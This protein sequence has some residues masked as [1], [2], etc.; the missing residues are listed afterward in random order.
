MT[1][2][3]KITAI[4]AMVLVI[5]ATSITA[6]AASRYSSPAEAVA[7]LTGKTV[8]SVIQERQDT[9]KSYGAIAED[10]GKLEEFKQEK[11]QILKDNL[12]KR[13]AD[14]TITQER[15]DEIVKAVEERQAVCDGTGTGGAGCGM[16]AGLGRGNG[17]GCGMGGCNQ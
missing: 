17:R 11:L 12:A 1:K 13:V 14:G 3:K 4:G 2:I 5:G 7:G 16:G 15:A 10:A 9:G 6:F 8:E